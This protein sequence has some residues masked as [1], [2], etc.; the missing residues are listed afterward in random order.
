MD[1]CTGGVI[2]K[3]ATVISDQQYAALTRSPDFVAIK[4]LLGDYLALQSTTQLKPPA[5]LIQRSY[6]A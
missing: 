3:Y 6:F 1:I 4:Q 2:Q 5:R